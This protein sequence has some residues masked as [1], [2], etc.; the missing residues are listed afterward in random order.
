MSFKESTLVEDKPLAQSKWYQKWR[1]TKVKVKNL[2]G[3]WLIVGWIKTISKV[4]TDKSEGKQ[5]NWLNQNKTKE[6]NKSFKEW[7]KTNRWLNQTKI[8]SED[9][10]IIN[11]RQT[12]GWI[13]RRRQRVRRSHR[14]HRSSN[15]HRRSRS[16][17]WRRRHRR[18]QWHWSSF[19]RISRRRST[20]CS[21][22][23]KANTFQLR[24]KCVWAKVKKW[25]TVTTM[26]QNLLRVGSKLSKLTVD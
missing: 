9:F 2:I 3:W 19:L 22:H 13:G 20:W 14:K 15:R 5:L 11:W 18:V 8:E 26:E 16:R 12:V 23:W 4:K 17:I 10:K 21:H 1:L 24:F 6:Q 25:Q 7:L